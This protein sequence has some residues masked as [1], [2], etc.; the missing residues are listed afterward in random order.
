MSRRSGAVAAAALLAALLL[1][2]AL[3]SGC[4]GSG[5]E[6]SGQRASA[7][8]RAR[9]NA[10]CRQLRRDVV[11]LGSGA[12]DGSTNLAEATTERV[13]K[14]SIPLLESFAARQQ[15]LARG[16]G[17]PEFELYARL[18]EPIV[19]LAY[20]RLRAGEEAESPFNVAARGFEILTSTVADE[21]QQVA[22][23]AG[24][25]DCAIDFEQVLTSALR[26]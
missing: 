18:F 16:T 17:D 12:F 8:V 15:R 13:I 1:S 21:Q 26:G 11:K 4:G 6:T 23:E 19:I 5:D 2:S 22:K 7:A 20:E 25:P 14:P 10:N 9:A 3:A 24:L